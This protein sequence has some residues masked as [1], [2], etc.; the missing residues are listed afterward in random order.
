MS[1]KSRPDNE[2]TI[3]S[4]PPPASYAFPMLA[5]IGGT[6][7]ETPTT[8]EATPT[9]TYD[10]AMRRCQQQRAASLAARPAFDL[11]GV[12]AAEDDDPDPTALEWWSVPR[13]DD[14]HER[15]GLGE[16]DDES[17][18]GL[19]ELT[20]EDRANIEAAKVEL[21]FDADVQVRRRPPR[22]GLASTTAAAAA[23][24]SSADAFATS[25]LAAGG[26][27]VKRVPR[28]GPRSPVRTVQIIQVAAASPDARSDAASKAGAFKAAS[29]VPSRDDGDRWARGGPT[30]SPGPPANVPTRVAV[31]EPGL[32][33]D[34]LASSPGA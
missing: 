26:G 5:C 2:S 17:D 24:G 6:A 1:H 7:E 30:A 10:E 22:N 21:L 14:G 29:E 3:V 4:S 23:N 18:G 16:N 28:G 8:P 27:A 12:D 31:V 20:A 32:H 9:E 11:S 33:D 25:S 15:E 13:D 19:A 34:D